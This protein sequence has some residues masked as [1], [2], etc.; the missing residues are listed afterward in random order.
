MSLGFLVVTPGN[1]AQACGPGQGPSLPQG[2][3]FSI[4][5][6]RVNSCP[7][8][9]DQEACLLLERAKQQPEQRQVRSRVRRLPREAQLGQ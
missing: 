9:P 1:L 6:T 3:C 8:W 7:G 2:F 5:K 4:C